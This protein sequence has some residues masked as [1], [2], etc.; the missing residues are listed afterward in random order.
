MMAH[1]KCMMSPE[2]HPKT[3]ICVKCVSKSTNMKLDTQ[4]K[5]CTYLRCQT[6]HVKEIH[7]CALSVGLVRQTWIVSYNLPFLGLCI[8]ENDL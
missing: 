8:Q 1:L 6:C 7:F 4:C 2:I 3:I 5:V